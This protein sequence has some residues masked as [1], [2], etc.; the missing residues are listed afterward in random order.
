MQG[1]C[2]CAWRLYT[3]LGCPSLRALVGLRASIC[4]YTSHLTPYQ[5]AGPIGEWS[6]AIERC[7]ACLPVRQ[8]SRH[9]LGGGRS[10]SWGVSPVP[11]RP[12]CHHHHHHRC[13]LTASASGVAAALARR[14]SASS[15][16]SGGR[17]VLR[18]RGALSS[19][20]ESCS[21]MRH[22]CRVDGESPRINMCAEQVYGAVQLRRRN[23]V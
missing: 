4:Q 10:C 11:C 9:R 6:V 5:S 15:T 7:Q 12:T 3:V 21:W 14:P 19:E 23:R 2:C 17:G 20:S 22:F 1:K 8:G 18:R 13:H 16:T